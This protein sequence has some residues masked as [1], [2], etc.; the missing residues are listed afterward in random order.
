MNPTYSCRR[1]YPHIFFSFDVGRHPFLDLNHSLCGN[2]NVLTGERP[3]GRADGER[4]AHQS[5]LHSTQV[6]KDAR[7]ELRRLGA[8][9]IAKDVARDQKQKMEAAAQA[10]AQALALAGKQVSDQ[11]ALRYLCIYA[12]HSLHLPRCFSCNGTYKNATSF[13]PLSYIKPSLPV[14]GG[15][16]NFAVS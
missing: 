12:P 6:K 3:E 11:G 13:L 14:M 9:E 7:K 2:R 15:R 8:D 4:Q 1:V 16:P 10:E 5:D